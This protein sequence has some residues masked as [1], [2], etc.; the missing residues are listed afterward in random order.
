M[1]RL[2]PARTPADDGVGIIEILV[3]MTIFGLIMAASV[4]LF[5]ASARTAARNAQL[6]TA[7]QIATQQVERARSAGTS[8][9]QLKGHLVHSTANAESEVHDSRGIEYDITETAASSITCPVASGLIT[10]T[11]TVTAVTNATTNPAKATLTTQ[12]WVGKS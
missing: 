5:I 8:C 11:V 3:A 10:Y 2:R 6:T 1:R 9:T 4:P 12:I 7:T